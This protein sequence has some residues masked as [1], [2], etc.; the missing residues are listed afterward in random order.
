MPEDSEIGTGVGSPLSATDSDGDPLQYSL[1]GVGQTYFQV[2][3]ATGQLMTT[4]SLN[5]E[6][7]S[8]Y[9]VQ[10][11]VDDDNGGRDVI[12]V[13][14]A[15]L[16]VDEPPSQPGVPQV[17][18]ASPA[19]LAVSWRAPAN[20]GPEIT[21]YDVQYREVGGGF[22]DAGYGGAG[23]SVTV[24]DLRPRDHLR[25]PGVG[26]STPRGPALG[27]NRAE[28]K[29]K[30]LCP[31]RFPRPRPRG[32]P[33]P[34]R[35]LGSPRPRRF[36]PRKLERRGLRPVPTPDAGAAGAT[37]VPTPDAGVTET[38]PAPTPVQTQVPLKAITELSRT[39]LTF[40]PAATLTPSPTPP[41]LAILSPNGRPHSGAAASSALSP[42]RLMIAASAFTSTC[43]GFSLFCCWSAAVILTARTYTLLCGGDSWHIKAGGPV[44]K[45]V[46]RSGASGL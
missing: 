25:G 7:Q 26:R 1:S 32:R 18:S 14:I 30:G 45:G 39:A 46:H 42:R 12:N 9:S 31:R 10:V 23:T 17:S 19:G 3:P 33:Y 44:L 4:A 37:P 21:D 6:S 34:P 41:S 5:Y 36:P 35:T 2:D 15:V 27:P 11:T 29:L 20:Q 16:D 28:V 24:N 22:Q 13:T 38:T 43:C 8:E 40:L